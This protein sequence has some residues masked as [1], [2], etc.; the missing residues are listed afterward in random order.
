MPSVTHS[1]QAQPQRRRRHKYSVLLP[2]YNEADN[3]ALIVWLLV[4]SFE[5]WCVS[6]GDAELRSSTAFGAMRPDLHS[7]V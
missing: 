6:C 1:Q 4:R 2:T 7:G 5:S 3:I